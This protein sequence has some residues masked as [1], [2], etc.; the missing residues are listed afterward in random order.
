MR[1]RKCLGWLGLPLNTFKFP[2]FKLSIRD[3]KQYQRWIPLKGIN[4]ALSQIDVTPRLYLIAI[5]L[6]KYGISTA[7]DSIINVH[8]AKTRRYA[9]YLGEIS[10]S[11]I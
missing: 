2:F 3:P 10:E 1:L 8:L 7:L 11:T 5:R 9:L 4:L 6:C